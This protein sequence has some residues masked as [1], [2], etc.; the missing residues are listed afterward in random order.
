MGSIFSLGGM[1]LGHVKRGKRFFFG[2]GR[3][4]SQFYQ[5]A[6][7][8]LPPSS[9]GARGRFILLIIIVIITNITGICVI[10]VSVGSPLTA[11]QELW[12]MEIGD[13]RS[14]APDQLVK[15][16]ASCM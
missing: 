16:M 7:L 5:V 12:N 11:F 10:I 13:L 3:S 14:F 2:I 6:R 15:K 9:M 1:R 8:F 4:K